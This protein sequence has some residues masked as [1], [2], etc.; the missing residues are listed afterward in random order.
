MFVR[1]YY[2][3]L[4][5]VMNFAKYLTKINEF[6]V[7]ATTGCSA[8]NAYLATGLQGFRSPVSLDTIMKQFN[9]MCS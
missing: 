1:I 9:S 6:T 2:F 4:K 5:I 8:M 3:D 7:L